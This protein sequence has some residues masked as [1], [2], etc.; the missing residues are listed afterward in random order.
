[1][2]ERAE[3]IRRQK[4]TEGKSKYGASSNSNFSSGFGN[5]MSSSSSS[6]SASHSVEPSVFEA[7]SPPPSFK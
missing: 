3:E 4:V 5:S 7:S 6:Y 1:M 2:L